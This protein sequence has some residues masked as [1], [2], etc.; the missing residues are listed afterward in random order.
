MEK[1]VKFSVTTR[2]F[3]GKNSHKW[4]TFLLVI[5]SIITSTPE[6][7][8]TKFKTHSHA[9]VAVLEQM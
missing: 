4:K 8:N 7:S 3:S 9:Y 2:I 5:A 6:T 1:S